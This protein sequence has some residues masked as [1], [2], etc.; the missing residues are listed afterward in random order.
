MSGVGS[1]TTTKKR[2]SLV[3]LSLVESAP[4]HTPSYLRDLRTGCEPS[5]VMDFR[6]GTAEVLARSDSISPHLRLFFFLLIY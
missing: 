3:S 1:E 5:G 6:H 2:R 4:S